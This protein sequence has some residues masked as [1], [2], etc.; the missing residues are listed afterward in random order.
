MSAGEW[1]REFT[2][3]VMVCDRTGI[4]VE[5]N[6]EAAV[7]FA[8]DGG[9]GLLG[10]NIRDC[11]PDPAR[12]K[13]ESLLAGQTTNAYFSTEHEEKRFF[14]QAPWFQDGQFAGMVEVSF[15]VPQDIPHFIRD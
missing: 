15:V 5:M 4:A 7:L 2:A 14:Y 11:H 1:V 6:D 8:G 10:S 3:E 12:G 9:R 13:L